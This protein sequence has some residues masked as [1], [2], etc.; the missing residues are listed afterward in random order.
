MRETYGRDPWGYEHKFNHFLRYSCCGDAELSRAFLL[1]KP[2]V[3]LEEPSWEEGQY[4]FRGEGLD[5]L[6][7]TS[8]MWCEPFFTLHHVDAQAIV[9][10][11]RFKRAVEP[12]VKDDDFVR[13]IDLWDYMRPHFLVVADSSIPRPDF[14]K[15]DRWT[16]IPV[17]AGQHVPELRSVD[18]CL[19]EC[20]ARQ[21]CLVWTFD[22]DIGCECRAS[23][24]VFGRFKADPVCDPLRPLSST[25]SGRVSQG[26]VFLGR[27]DQNLPGLWSGWS[28]SRL[29]QLRSRLWCAGRLGDLGSLAYRYRSL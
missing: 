14:I 6:P 22:D 2:D 17:G 4:S 21:D 25:F 10:L 27:F 11:Q 1:S 28:L 3:K 20:E 19:R 7:L 8:S 15:R 18:T 16:A 26:E 29:A 5:K 13:W 23:D 9:E 24:V 12:L